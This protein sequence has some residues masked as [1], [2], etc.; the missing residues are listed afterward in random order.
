M[1]LPPTLLE[2]NATPTLNELFDASLSNALSSKYYK[3]K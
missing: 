2:V 3:A 1:L